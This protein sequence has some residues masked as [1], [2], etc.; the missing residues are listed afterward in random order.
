[1]LLDERQPMSA[2]VDSGL[3]GDA[4]RLLLRNGNFQR[5]SG[6]YSSALRSNNRAYDISSR[7]LGPEHPDT[8]T[9]AN[10][11]AAT[12]RA[13]GDVNA[14]RELFVEALN[15]AQHVWGRDHPNTKTIRSNLE[16]CEQQ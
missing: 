1:M 13:L 3:V 4:I 12:L 10:N 9:S 5:S 11:L 7:T 6:D 15:G 14:A 16:R 8:L 2:K